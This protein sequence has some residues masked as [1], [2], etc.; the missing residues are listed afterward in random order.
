MADV[1][2]DKY[3]RAYDKQLRIGEKKEISA[4]RSYYKDQYNKG[5]EEF[6][7]TGK[8]SGLNQLFIKNKF[9]ELYK[10][11]Y[12]NIGLRFASWYANNIDKYIVK[13]L[14]TS[15]YKDTWE[16]IF[17]KEGKRVA[18]V[19]VVTVQGTAKKELEKTLKKLM[20]D[21]DFQSRGAAEKGRILR[22]R[23]NKLGRYQAERIVRTEATNAANLGVMQSAT[24]VYGKNSLQK[25]WITS[26]DGRERSAHAM[27]NGQI[28][29]FNDK[30]KVGGELLDRAG[31]PTASAVNVVNCRCAIAPFPKPEAQTVTPLTGFDYG[32]SAGRAIGLDS[33]NAVDDI[34][35]PKPKPQLV[36]E[37]SE[38]AA[39]YEFRPNNWDD[40]KGS[41]DFDDSYLQY[42]KKPIKLQEAPMVYSRKLGKMVEDGAYFNKENRIIQISKK[43]HKGYESQVLAHEFGHAINTDLKLISWFKADS[44]IE[45]L[46]QKH[47]SIFIDRNTA[48]L[49]NKGQ[50]LRKNWGGGKTSNTSNNN[51]WK[52]YKPY[53]E[54][55]IKKDF[56]NMSQ[57]ELK[58][59]AGAVADYLASVSD[60]KIGWGHEWSG[61]FRF[62]HLQYE[63]FMAHA[64]EN[65]FVGN[66]IFKKYFPDL[67]DDLIKLVDELLKNTKYDATAINAYILRK[68]SRS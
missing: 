25:K 26:M 57:L 58:E 27:A 40:F 34:L 6:L 7:K 23:F 50:A 9:D 3:I 31:D 64:Y 47:S 66:P 44:R 54:N 56:P 61:Y 46:F 65:R 5:V 4:V 55:K 68:L 42:L 51:Y 53:F 60:C 17:A 67:Y 11:I 30:F 24:D 16:T 49:T 39:K 32:M 38:D 2:D 14:E 59:N 19:R 41:K 8:T 36:T 21:V 62:K 20:T 22:Q 45:A 52:N 35:K 43:R 10:S 15:K 63:E 1:K 18:A 33:A 29:D 48:S 12:V 13:Q 37:V 28:V